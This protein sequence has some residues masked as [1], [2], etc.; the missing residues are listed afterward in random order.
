ME[1]HRLKR[2]EAPSQRKGDTA[3]KQL[4]SRFFYVHF[5]FPF[6]FLFFSFCK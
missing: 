5:H 4:I 1:K 3:S 6:S 2:Q